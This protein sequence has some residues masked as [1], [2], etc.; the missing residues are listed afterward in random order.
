MRQTIRNFI[1]K[2]VG[3]ID[4][5]NKGNKTVYDF[6]GRIKGYYKKDSIQV[7]ER[8]KNS[9]ENF[10]EDMGMMPSEEYSIERID[11]N[12]DYCPENC[13]WILQK[14]QSKNSE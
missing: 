6:Q 14:E 12:K 4:T 10:I 2:I 5:D 11:Y 13:K 3:Y 1:G 7:C 8:W 9:F